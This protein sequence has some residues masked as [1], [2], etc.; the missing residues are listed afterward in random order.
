MLR[1]TFLLICERNKLC[2]VLLQLVHSLFMFFLQVQNVLAKVY[3]YSRAW[4][5]VTLIFQI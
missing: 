4:I 1:Y 2:N 5:L 3:N